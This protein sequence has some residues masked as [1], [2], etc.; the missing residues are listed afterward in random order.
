MTMTLVS[1]VTL[2]PAGAT[3]IIFSAIPQTGQDLYVV[4]SARNT[5][6]DQKLWIQFNSSA[7]GYVYRGLVGNGSSAYSGLNGDGNDR[8]AT[9]SQVVP[10]AA[11]TFGNTAIYIPNYTSS[12]AKSVSIDAVGE[13]NA[14]T[15]YMDI[16]AASW[17]GTA[18]ITSVRLFLGTTMVQ[19]TTA[20]LYTISTTG[21]SGASVA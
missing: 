19:N 10:L 11:N 13:Q 15:S 8:I 18:A 14:A 20:S 2:G 6:S 9:N 21:A 5:N 4:L 3:E 7:A 16:D 12:A 17:S 1:T